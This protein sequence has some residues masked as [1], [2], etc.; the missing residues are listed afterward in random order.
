MLLSF[1]VVRFT[2]FLQPLNQHKHSMEDTSLPSIRNEWHQANVSHLQV[3]PHRSVPWAVANDEAR[4]KSTTVLS[5][6]PRH[7]IR[8]SEPTTARVVNVCSQAAAA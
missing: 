8:A 3:P 1:P 2:C 5:R 7:P 4:C 6:T